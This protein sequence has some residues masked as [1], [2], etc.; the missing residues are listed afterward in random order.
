MRSISPGLKLALKDG[1]IAS[2]IKITLKNG[3]VYGYTDHDISLTVDSVTYNPAPGLAKIKQHQTIKSDVSNQ[4]LQS[5]WVDAPASDLLAGTFDEAA[6]EVSW[7]SWADV[8]LGKVTTFSGHLGQITW[9]VDGFHAD[10]YSLA[11]L[12]DRVINLLYIPTCRHKLYG[13]AGVGL[14]HYCGLNAATYTSTGSIS[15][16]VTSKWIFGI[17]T[18]QADAY[19]TGASITFTSGNNTGLTYE[20]KNHAANQI[21]L[22]LPTAFIVAAGDTYS[23]T[24]GCDKTLT[25]CKNKFNNVANFGGFPSIQPQ[26][27]FR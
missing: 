6:L 17:S 27:N 20:V 12:L 21:E 10:A 4:T 8:S 3:T 5:G 14:M 13:T 24:A 22:Y 9:D 7:C 18:A 11:K 23:I 16:V 1:R 19:Y 15:S 26:V 25:T 2:L